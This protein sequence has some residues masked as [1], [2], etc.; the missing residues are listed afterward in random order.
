MEHGEGGN[1]KGKAKTANNMP[2]LW[3]G[4]HSKVYSGTSE[5]DIRERASDRL[6]PA[7][8]KSDRKSDP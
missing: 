3:G 5:V 2:I 6:K 7:T 4:P 1:I 8:S